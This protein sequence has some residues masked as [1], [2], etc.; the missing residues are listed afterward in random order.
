MTSLREATS[1]GQWVVLQSQ[2]LGGAGPAM[3]PPQ[4][5]GLV[6]I[7]PE[8]TFYLF[9][10]PPTI[11]ESGDRIAFAATV[12]GQGG[13]PQLYTVRMDR[14][15]RITPRL[16]VGG[17]FT[18]RL[19]VNPNENGVILMGAGSSLAANLFALPNFEYGLALDP[20]LPIL[21]VASGMSGSGN[22]TITAPIGNDP[23]FIGVSVFF[24]GLRVQPNL[25]GDF[26]RYAEA[27]VF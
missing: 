13:V 11:D 18:V 27:S 15:L 9:Q 24:Q 17:Q 21:P 4:G 26:T 10:S 20:S 22:L 8:D 6:V 12:L 16:E 2:Y 3:I 1:D 19:P 14:D 7:D 5:G 23:S 25:T